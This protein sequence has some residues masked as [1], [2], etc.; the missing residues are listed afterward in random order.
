MKLTWNNELRQCP[1]MCRHKLY[2]CN[3]LKKG[4]A[5]IQEKVHLGIVGNISHCEHLED[6]TVH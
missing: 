2:G 5:S 6:I 4:K 3:N 1:R